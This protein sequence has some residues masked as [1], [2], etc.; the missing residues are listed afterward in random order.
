MKGYD[1]QNQNENDR[2]FDA[3][4]LVKYWDEWN[5][6]Y[7]VGIIVDEDGEDILRGKYSVFFADTVPGYLQPTKKHGRVVFSCHDAI[8]EKIWTV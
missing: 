2:K 1:A 6:V 8:L 5:E 3:G 7:H 4:D